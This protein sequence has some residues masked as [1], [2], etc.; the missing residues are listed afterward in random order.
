MNKSGCDGAV[1]AHAK[2][3]RASAQASRLSA[4]RRIVN[5]RTHSI[6]NIKSHL[7]SAHIE[8]LCSHWLRHGS[9]QGGWWVCTT[10]WRDDTK[11]SL[12]VSLSTGRWKDFA[13]SE[14]GDI[15]DLSMKL[16]GDT[17]ADTLSGFAE[18]LGL[19]DGKG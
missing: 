11:P 6:E 19:G 16:F 14:A 7:T 15:F 17:L 18:M 8:A 5:T 2:T 12:G 10:P 1:Q 3:H 9:K 13:T 4:P